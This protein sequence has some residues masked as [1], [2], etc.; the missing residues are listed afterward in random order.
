ALSISTGRTHIRC[1]MER[2]RPFIFTRTPTPKPWPSLDPK[3]GC[4]YFAGNRHSIVSKGTHIQMKLSLIVP[5]LMAANLAVY[6]QEAMPRMTTVEPQAGKIGDVVA[7]AGENLDKTNVAKVYLTDGK[8][9][10]ICEVTE[11]TATAI[12]IKIPV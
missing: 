7:V 5:L 3:P 11:Q 12:K 8:N 9:D 1:A 10:V 2:S 6:A 4:L